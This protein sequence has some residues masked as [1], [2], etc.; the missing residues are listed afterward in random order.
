MSYSTGIVNN[1]NDLRTALTN[2]C[3]DEGWTWDAGNQVLH[4][5]DLFLRIT[6]N[7][8]NLEFLGRTALTTGN[9]PTVVAMGILWQNGA[10]P[11][12][13]IA[14]PATYH[15]FVSEEE[16]Y[17]V[18]NY[19]VDRFQWAAFGKSTIENLSGTGLWV[20]AI[21][22]P[23]PTI[24]QAT[25]GPIILQLE[26]VNSV[27]STGNGNQIS[28]L[29]FGATF[30]QNAVHVNKS[31]HVHSNLD[32]VGWSMNVGATTETTGWNEQPGINAINPL[33]TITPSAW[34]SEGVLLPIR[35]Y[36][37]RPENRMSLIADLRHARYVR[38]DNYEPGQI[39]TLGSDTWMVFPWHQKN[40]AARNGGSNITHTGTFG[41][42][43]R[44]EES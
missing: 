7:G 3:T 14:F 40:I 28:P 23:S 10:N 18:V 20:A 24:I 30:F 41:W 44:Y 19:S 29:M 35:A 38:I 27:W 34:N 36:K 39:I 32:S 33:Y 22:G 13:E 15:I 1:I 12:Y 25:G 26:P 11:T 43:I 8:V 42:A 17:L 2:A 9:A 4:K 31:Y 16:V 5:D 6:I 37:Q 21:R